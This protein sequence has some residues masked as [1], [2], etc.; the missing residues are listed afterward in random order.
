ML[1]GGPETGTEPAVP[2]CVLPLKERAMRTSQINPARL[3]R[4]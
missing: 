3:S 1:N 4:T 2:Y